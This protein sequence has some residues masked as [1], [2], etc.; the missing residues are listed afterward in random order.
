MNNLIPN[1]NFSS[2]TP[3]QGLREK[4]FNFIMK[5]MGYNNQL[6]MNH[7]Q[8][9]SYAEHKWTDAIVSELTDIIDT[10]AEFTLGAFEHPQITT[11]T[12][13]IS[14]INLKNSKCVLDCLDNDCKEMIQE[15]KITELE[16]MINLLG[17]LDGIIKKFKFLST[18][19]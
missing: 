11:T 3:E 5:L 12:N 13:T 18:L 10:I 8:T 9:T 2:L 14:D 6:K 1:Y 15:F 17:E 4:T 7:W 16:G 19:E